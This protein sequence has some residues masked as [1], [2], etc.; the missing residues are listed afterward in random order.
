MKP[1][2]NQPRAYLLALLA[3]VFWSTM[4]S[5]FKITLRHIAFDQLVMWASLTGVIV[6]GLINQLGKTPLRLKDLNRQALAA[7]ALMGFINPFLYYLV[8][9]KAYELLEAQIAGTLNYAWPIV[10]VLL[11][12]P[13]LKQRI[14]FL[15][16]L[17]ILISFFGI[18]VISTQ[19]R[20]SGLQGVNPLGV[21]LALSSALLWALY[22]ILNLKDKREVTG[23][24]WLN[25]AFGFAYIVIYLMFGEEGFQFPR[26]NALAGVV[27]IG[28]FEMSITFVV[29]LMALTYSSNT[30][31]VSHLI[32]L[33]PFFALFWIHLAVGEPI[34]NSTIIGLA[35]IVLGI[36]LQQFFEFKRKI[37]DLN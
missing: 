27:Y 28:A 21:A 15:S 10:L 8:L 20:L 2:S 26:G 29:W 37:A 6:L 9:F 36:A 14:S 3:V 30:A 12:V 16:I 11:S 1:A 33:S 32:Y 18:V 13:L 22:W 25:L 35:F 19:G 23:K 34:R 4:S 5:A 17:T 24:I 31:K 7:S